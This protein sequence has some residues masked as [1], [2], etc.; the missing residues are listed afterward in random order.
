MDGVPRVHAYREHLVHGA[1][2]GARKSALKRRLGVRL[3][4]FVAHPRAC[5]AVSTWRLC[6]IGTAPRRQRRF[7]GA[8]VRRRRVGS[9]SALHQLLDL[10]EDAL[11]MW[12]QLDSA[13]VEQII[14]VDILVEVAQIL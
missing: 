14:V 13:L 5:M 4:E 8:L 11:A 6:G 3:W 9:V 1:H 12:P 10:C 2:V 7:R